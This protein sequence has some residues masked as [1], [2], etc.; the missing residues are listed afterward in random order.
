LFFPLFFLRFRYFQE[1]SIGLAD[2]VLADTPRTLDQLFGNIG[3]AGAV[4]RVNAVDVA[5]PKKDVGS[6]AAL[7]DGRGEFGIMGNVEQS[8]TGADTGINGRISPDPLLEA[9]RLL[10]IANCAKYVRSCD[11]GNSGAE[12]FES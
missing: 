8:T 2:D 4:V 7:A 12:V 11:Y 9:E 5:D 1:V 10:E 6:E 3:T